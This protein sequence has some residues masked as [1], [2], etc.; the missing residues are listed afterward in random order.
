MSD[1][2]AI[3]GNTAA[4]PHARPPGPRG[5]RP[6]STPARTRCSR[7]APAPSPGGECGNPARDERRRAD[8]EQPEPHP[9]ERGPAMRPSALPVIVNS[10]AAEDEDRA[11]A[12]S[13][14]WTR[15][16]ATIRRYASIVGISRIAFAGPA[17]PDEPGV[18]A[19]LDEPQ[20]EERHDPAARDP[21]DDRPG[22]E[23]ARVRVAEQA[24][25]VE[26]PDP[27]TRAA[28]RGPRPRSAAPTIPVSAS[29]GTYTASIAA[30]AVAWTSTPT[31]SVARMKP[32]RPERAGLPEP[33][34]CPA[35]PFHRPRV[36]ERRQ[37]GRPRGQDG[38][39]EHD[40]RHRRVEREQRRGDGRPQAR[41]RA[42]AGARRPAGPRQDPRW[43]R[44]RSPR[45][46]APP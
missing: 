9:A 33:V 23:E 6:R 43:A 34:P 3:T 38:D 16:R 42:A 11:P 29:G 15:T 39:H 31:A 35:K 37:A 17:D 8:E 7:T 41:P 27:R 24:Q 2:T 32:E 18:A 5:S 40:P 13:S 36:D 30:G 14:H 21:H 1:P 10:R 22:E 44:R 20:A 45:R 19:E 25:G 26:R 4:R 28:A 12:T 46:R